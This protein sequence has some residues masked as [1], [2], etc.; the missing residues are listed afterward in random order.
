MLQIHLPGRHSLFVRA[1]IDSGASGNFIDHEYVAQNGI[2][3]RIKDWPILVEAIDGRPIA[4]GPVVHET[5]DLIVDLGDHREVLSFDV[6]QSPFFPIVLGVRWLST[7]DP[8]ITWSTRSIV[9]DSEYC[10]RRLPQRRRPDCQNRIQRKAAYE[11]AI[12]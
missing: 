1:M 5:H 12:K 9:F 7:H 8:N 2:P 4:S 11:P 6:T 3:L 10:R